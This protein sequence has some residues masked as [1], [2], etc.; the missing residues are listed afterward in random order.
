MPLFAY[1]CKSCE[2]ASEILVRGSEKP[3]CPECGSAQLEKQMSHC[4][5]MK[6][7][8]AAPECASHCSQAGSCPMQGGGCMG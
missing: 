4:A 2:A 8:A 5:P 3:K 7:A 1:I 6:S